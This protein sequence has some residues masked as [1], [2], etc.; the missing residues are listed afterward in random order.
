MFVYLSRVKSTTSR[1]TLEVGPWGME[2]GIGYKTEKRKNGRIFI[3]GRNSFNFWH[4]WVFKQKEMGEKNAKKKKKRIF[5]L[6][7]ICGREII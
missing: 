3:P 1:E 5:E 4:P 7:A 6:S 2:Q